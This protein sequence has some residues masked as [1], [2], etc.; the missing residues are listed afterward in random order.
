MAYRTIKTLMM[1]WGFAVAYFC[2]EDAFERSAASDVCHQQAMAEQGIGKLGAYDRM[3]LPY[4]VIIHIRQVNGLVDF[5]NLN[6][7]AFRTVDEALAAIDR[8][9]AIDRAED[10]LNFQV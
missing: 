4:E 10:A 2:P 5:S 9:T 8:L 3:R 6:I 1:P 7:K